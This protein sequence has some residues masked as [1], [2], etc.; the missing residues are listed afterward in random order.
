MPKQSAQK[1]ATVVSKPVIPPT[2][3]GYLSRHQV[4]AY[5]SLNIQTV[6]KHKN[7]GKLRFSRVGRRILF[8]RQDVDQWLAQ[9]QG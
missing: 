9:L 8:R 7:E 1:S 2:S 4:A 6:D 5:T 3:D